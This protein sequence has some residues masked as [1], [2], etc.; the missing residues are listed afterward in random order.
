MQDRRLLTLA[1]A[2]ALT[3]AGNPVW[4]DA[5][6]E[7]F[8]HFGGVLGIGASDISTVEYLQGLKMREESNLKFTG[9]VLG[10]L[11]KLMGG[12]NGKDSIAIL[13]VD[14]NKHYSLDPKTKTYTE[15]PI[16]T[17]PK[18]M[19]HTEGTKEDDTKITKNELDVK[20][21]GQKK[22][23]N[24]FDC[25][26]YQVTWLL[27][28]VNVKTQKK[29]KSLM[30]TDM[31]NTDDAKLK[32]LRDQELTYGKAFLTLMHI[33]YTPEQAK[34]YGFGQVQMD[35]LTQEDM[36]KFFAKLAAIKGYPVSLDVLWK[37]EGSAAPDTPAGNAAGD[38]DGMLNLFSSHTE[39]K[40]VDTAALKSDLFTVPAG[41]A[42]QD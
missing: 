24:G 26:E 12:T 37:A 40:S 21:T 10:G 8:T 33:P 30:T 16:Y 3:L 9:S 6:I 27:E 18:P 4:A 7:R 38:D 36:Q 34:Q 32:A 23:V 42:Q 22:T 17:P 5:K 31:W 2:S 1:V 41:Y 39:L 19:K 20:E 35:Y 14:E 11:Q 29:G 13:R 28:T 15:H 25:R